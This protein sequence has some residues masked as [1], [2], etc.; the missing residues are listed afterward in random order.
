MVF[1]F[2]LYP[3]YPLL[4]QYLLKVRYW[5]YI[6]HFFGKKWYFDTIYNR[7]FVKPFWNLGY[8]VTYKLIDKGW[9]EFIGP[10]GLVNLITFISKKFSQFQSGFLSDYVYNILLGLLFVFWTLYKSFDSFGF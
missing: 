3:K 7:Y 8:N 2:I 6:Y 1:C 5:N 4:L 9:L 10:T